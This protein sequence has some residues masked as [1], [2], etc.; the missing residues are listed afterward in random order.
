MDIKDIRVGCRYKSF[1]VL[2]SAHVQVEVV[3][4]SGLFKGEYTIRCS[5]CIYKEAG[6]LCVM[7]H[8]EIT[9]LLS[10]V[11]T[12]GNFPKREEETL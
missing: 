11:N 10:D 1:C 4:C 3:S 9:A 12:L 2:M 6:N 5:G 7:F 8:D